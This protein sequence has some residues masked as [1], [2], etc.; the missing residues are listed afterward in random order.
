MHLLSELDELVTKHILQVWL[1]ILML[2]YVWVHIE[3]AVVVNLVPIST[4]LTQC[5]G[6]IVPGRVK[7][8]YFLIR[9]SAIVAATD[10][11]QS[12][13]LWK[14]LAIVFI[15]CVWVIL[16][17]GVS[18]SLIFISIKHDFIL[19]GLIFSYTLTRLL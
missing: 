15:L 11:V 9:I 12:S 7:S 10:T 3:T 13:C 19:I 2:L 14:L 16:W 4:D 18:G 8:S 6:V 5:H 1:H 17:L